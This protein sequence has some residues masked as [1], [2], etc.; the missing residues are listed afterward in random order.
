MS[1]TPFSV[2]IQASKNFNQCTA[3]ATGLEIH[4]ITG[5]EQQAFGLYG[6]GLYQAIRAIMGA[7]PDTVWLYDPTM[8]GADHTSDKSY[9]YCYDKFGW[10][11]VTT[12]LRAISAVPVGL[13]TSP[14]IVNHTQWDNKTDHVVNYSAGLSAQES[15][16]VSHSWTNSDKVSFGGKI[17]IKIGIKGFEGGG[18]ATFNYE[19]SWSDTKTESKTITVGTNASAQSE[20]PAHTTETAYLFSTLGSA[21]YRVTYQ[22]TLSGAVAYQYE[23]W[24]NGHRYYAVDVNYVLATMGVPN[25]VTITEDISVGF[26]SDASI[27]VVPGPY[28]P[29]TRPSPTALLA[30][31][32]L[33]AAAPAR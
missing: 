24:Y 27:E 3:S 28:N 33:L 4:T 7:R 23:S 20:V 6:D 11:P 5:T 19:Q 1:Q 12:T 14:V 2:D 17:A 8:G 21:L 15:E 18:D 31:G 13:S 10:S 29:N 9:N 30:V 32:H 26:Y 16:T 25:T 22:A